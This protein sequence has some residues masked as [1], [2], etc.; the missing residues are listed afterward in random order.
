MYSAYLLL[1]DSKPILYEKEKQGIKEMMQRLNI[2]I[3][4]ATNNT[5]IEEII[6]SHQPDSNIVK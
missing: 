2:N 6:N 3:G 1:T 4:E 5:G